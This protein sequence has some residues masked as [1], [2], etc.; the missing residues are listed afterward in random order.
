MKLQNNK[1]KKYIPEYTEEKVKKEKPTAYTVG[2]RYISMQTYD[3]Q[4]AVN[5]QLVIDNWKSG[6]EDKF[7]KC[8]IKFKV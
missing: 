7:W 4:S 3:Q 6:D 5:A 1:P 2:N 8:F